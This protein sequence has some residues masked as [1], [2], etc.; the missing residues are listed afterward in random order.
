MATEKS[1]MKIAFIGGGSENWAPRIIRDIIFQ[2]GM[3][4]LGMEFALLDIDMPRAQAI[5]DLFQVKLAEW[6]V[7]RV[8]TWPTLDAQAAIADADFV[9]I[10]ISTGRLPAMKHDLEIPDKYG[11]YHTVGDTSGPGGW[12]RALRNIPVFKAYAEQIRRQAPAAHVFNYTNPMGALTKVL[13]DELPQGRVVGLCHGLFECYRVL[14][15]IFELESEEQIQ[16][17]F[18][19]VNHFFWILDM[20]V[21]GQDGYA[22]L[23][24]KLQGRNFA[25]LVKEIHRDDMGFGSDKWLAGELFDNYGYLPYVGDRHTCEF[26]G[27]YITDK[28]MMERF[29]LVRTSIA[30]REEGYRKA[31]ERIRK[32]TH[33]EEAD[34]TLDRQ[35]SRETAADIIKAITFNEGFADVVNTVNTGQI[36][37][38]PLGGVVETMGYIDGRGFTPFTAGPLPDT[39][40]PLLYPHVEVQIR[41]VAAGLS[42][43]LDEALLALAADPACAHMTV[44]DVKKMGME[45]LEANCQYLPQ[46][47]GG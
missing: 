17:R 13:S 37:N 12:A 15:A 41:T 46:F 24:D 28:A 16:V 5:H 22:L 1:N 23:R 44:S 31:G 21:G 29:K 26:F 40:K 7:D 47:F 35:P 2:E 42:G 14:Q 9:I 25:N 38:L 27:C 20:K 6:G 30:Q 19:G 11:I 4:G 18:G 43:D 34:D 10:T 32:W 8:R 3:E 36:P 39:L 33:G 45:L